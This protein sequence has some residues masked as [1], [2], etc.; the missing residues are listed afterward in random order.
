MWAQSLPNPIQL[1]Q[2]TNYIQQVSFSSPKDTFF[3]SQ[4]TH[5]ISL[6]YF[7]YNDNIQFEEELEESDWFYNSSYFQFQTNLYYL[8]NTNM[9]KQHNL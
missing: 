2:Y 7:I 5:Y 1:H 9:N 3:E 8:N 6:L 4:Y